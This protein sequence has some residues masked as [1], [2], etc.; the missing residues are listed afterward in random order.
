MPYATIPPRWRL[1]L[2][3]IWLA[4]AVALTLLMAFG[5]TARWAE[6]QTV[7]SGSHCATLVLSPEE[8]T[9]LEARGF[10]LGAYAA[11]LLA[12]DLIVAVVFGGLS[13]LLFW[14][15]SA[16]W[17]GYIGSLAFLFMGTIF[18]S[19]YPRA[20]VRQ[21]PA[22]EPLNAALTTVAIALFV[23]QFYLFP[24]GRFVPRW[25]AGIVALCGSILL[26]EPLLLPD[27]PQAASA[28]LVAVA[29][30]AA[31]AIFGII[32]LVY[33]F[34]YV[35]TP[36]QRQ[37]MKW[38][39][40]GFVCMF[41]ASMEWIIFMELFPLEPGP[42]RLAFIATML[43]QYLL[44]A[45]LPLSFVI[46]F[47]RHQLWDIDIIIR[48]TLV[49]AL[50]S[51]LL[52][53][54]YFGSVVALQTIFGRFISGQ[55]PL[56]L[57]ISTLLI[58]ALFTPLRNRVQTFIDR[59]F[60]RQKYDAQQVLAQ[61]AQTVRDEVELETLRTELVNVVQQTMQPEHASVWLRRNK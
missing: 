11:Y 24:D 52:A 2:R 48:R 15:K 49:Y 8:L 46:A 18:Y 60:Y 6:L 50:L 29:V 28:T 34:R 47:L 42:Q 31:G 58:A 44:L 54:T 32:S 25:F 57:V 1:P 55:S 38:V 40:G 10:T 35:A 16:D 5:S 4:C 14:R 23:L 9:L 13:A 21:L 7:C 53:L 56:V 41:V 27:G 51:G 37:Q 26:L 43:P 61:F 33:R 59:R 22:L 45:C 30:A 20:L 39:M 36:I 3:A 19:D 17:M 12:V